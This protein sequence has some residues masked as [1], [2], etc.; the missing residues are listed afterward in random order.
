MGRKGIA[1]K[2][3]FSPSA[4]QMCEIVI[5]VGQGNFTYFV[6]KKSG[7]S[8]SFRNLWLW[9]PRLEGWRWGADWVF[10]LALRGPVGWRVGVTLCLLL[11]EDTSTPLPGDSHMWQKIELS[12]LRS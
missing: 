2:G 7:K 11:V 5:S 8:Q 4:G 6:R 12:A 10:H 3:R 9:Q 1:V